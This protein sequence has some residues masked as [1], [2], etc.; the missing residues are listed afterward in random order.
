MEIKRNKDQRTGEYK[1]KLAQ[2]SMNKDKS[3][4]RS[5]SHKAGKRVCR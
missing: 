1:Y 4:K 2:K 5:I 3:R